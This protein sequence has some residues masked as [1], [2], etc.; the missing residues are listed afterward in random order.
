MYIQLAET[1]DPKQFFEFAY[2]TSHTHT[3]ASKCPDANCLL[4]NK[5]DFNNIIVPDRSS[6][7]QREAHHKVC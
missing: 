4:T 1:A 7:S 6:V 2:R 3:Y 5:I